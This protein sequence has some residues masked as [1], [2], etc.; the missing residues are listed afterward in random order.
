[1]VGT[2]Y[3]DFVINP[4]HTVVGILAALRYRNRTGRGQCVELA[5]VESVV[6]VLGSAVAD[7]L[8]T[9]NVQTRSG[10]RSP[11][12]APQGAFRC[13]DDPE[14]ATAHDRWVAISCRTEGEWRALARAL[15]HPE[16]TG[17]P[18]FSSFEARKSNE[19]AIE[20]LVGSW[21]RDRRAED[22]A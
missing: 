11:I 14:I 4:G 1:G 21:M 9:G 12:A 10:N 8:S 15:G 2:N 3:P 18:R 6:N 17:D 13:L 7:Y 5:Q 20:A 16:A 22:V 19:D